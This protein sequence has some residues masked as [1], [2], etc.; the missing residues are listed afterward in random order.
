[1]FIKLAALLATTVLAQSQQREFDPSGMSQSEM[2][3][4]VD[5]LAQLSYTG[6]ARGLFSASNRTLAISENCFGEWIV[7]DLHEMDDIVY[8]YF[9][10]NY[11]MD[12]MYT[13]VYDLKDL[14]YR[15]T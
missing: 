8:D 6:F 15:N 1:M 7:D 11:T 14:L 10:G 13:L 5:K 9:S 4:F 12:Q 2:V 3:L